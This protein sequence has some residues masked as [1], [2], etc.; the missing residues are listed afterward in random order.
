MIHLKIEEIGDK[1]GIIFDDHAIEVLG[2]AVGDEL[3]IEETE[4]GL[5]VHV[6]SAD[7]GGHTFRAWI[8]PAP[9][10]SVP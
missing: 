9:D 7:G 8:G 5:L 1:V 10:V 4:G 6:R 2:I 3:Q